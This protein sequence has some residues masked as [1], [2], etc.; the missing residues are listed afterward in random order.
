MHGDRDMFDTVSTRKCPH[1][2]FF[3]DYCEQCDEGGEDPCQ[4]AQDCSVDEI[5]EWRGSGKRKMP[6]IQ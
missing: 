2:L 6:K 3:D 5:P 4:D 1:D